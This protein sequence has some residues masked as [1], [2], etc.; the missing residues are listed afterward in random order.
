MQERRIFDNVPDRG[1][2]HYERVDLEE[3]VIQ[4]K[5]ISLSQPAHRTAVSGADH[6]K[7]S[8]AVLKTRWVRRSVAV[9]GGRAR[10]RAAPYRAV[11]HRSGRHLQAARGSR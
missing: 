4:L 2:Q 3:P 9:A 5:K 10:S 6:N 1:K 7:P 8:L 11:L